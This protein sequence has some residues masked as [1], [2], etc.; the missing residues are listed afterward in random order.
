VLTDDDYVF[1]PGNRLLSLSNNPGLGVP[2]FGGG[3]C[4]LVAGV[5][6]EGF[7][8]ASGCAAE[9]GPDCCAA[10]EAVGFGAF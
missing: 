1:F 3:A 2:G 4:A 9:E 8:G 6:A 10:G 5:P 7:E